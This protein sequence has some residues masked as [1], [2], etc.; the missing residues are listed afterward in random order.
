MFFFPP[1]LREGTV[2]LCCNR[3]T[4][5]ISVQVKLSEMEA[6]C[7]V[8]MLLEVQ[9]WIFAVGADWW[10]V[11]FGGQAGGWVPNE[12]RLLALVEEVGLWRISKL[13]FY[14]AATAIL[15][16]SFAGLVWLTED[17]FFLLCRW[18]PAA[19][20]QAVPHY[21]DMH[22]RGRFLAW[23]CSADGV[24]QG[25]I[26]LPPVEQELNI[27]SGTEWWDPQALTVC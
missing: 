15:L 10:Q 27:H 11:G 14:F 24:L 5:F 22:S 3:K 1:C 17:L 13:D 9:I 26:P 18:A 8:T 7:I 19:Q 21:P 4:V 20:W 6:Q 2:C 12:S 16:F 25:S 23:S